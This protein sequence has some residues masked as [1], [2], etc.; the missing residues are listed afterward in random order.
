[1]R[2]TGRPRQHGAG[3]AEVIV[4]PRR[5]GIDHPALTHLGL[6][7]HELFVSPVCTENFIRIDQSRCRKGRAIVDF[8]AWQLN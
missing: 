6:K 2:M 4:L 5:T 8:I 7:S 3:D 1:M